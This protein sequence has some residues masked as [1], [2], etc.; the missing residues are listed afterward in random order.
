MAYLSLKRFIRT[1]EAAV[2]PGRF[3]SLAVTVFID[4]RVLMKRFKLKYAIGFYI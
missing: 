2:S 4:S 3:T 1:L